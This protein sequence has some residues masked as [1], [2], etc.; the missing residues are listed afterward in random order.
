MDSLYTYLAIAG[1]LLIV[2]LFN[3]RKNRAGRRQRKS[4]NFKQGYMERKKSNKENDE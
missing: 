1:V 3:F 2:F 4:R